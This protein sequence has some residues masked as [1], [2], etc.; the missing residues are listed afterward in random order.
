[1]TP[2]D[3]VH[4]MMQAGLGAPEKALT[5]NGK[6][7]RF[8]PKKANWYSLRETRTDS[9]QYIVL[10]SFGSWKTG[11]KYKVEVD[12]Q[13]INEAER[14]ELQ[15]KR[16]A[17]AD[18]DARARAAA[19]ARAAMTAGEL[20]AAASRTGA[21]DY[22]RRKGVD[23]E[24][25]RF[26][27]DG[28]IVIP[29]LRYDLPREDALRALQQI[30]TDGS[31]RFTKGLQKPGVCLRLGLVQVGEPMLVCEGYAT[32][33]TL[34]MA[35]GKRL[36]VFVAL[37]AGNLLPVCELLRTLYPRSKLLICAD[38]DYRTPGNP[39]REKAHKASRAVDRCAYTYPVF[40]PQMRGA[41]DTDFNDLHVRFGLNVVQR[42]LRHVLPALGSEILHAA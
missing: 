6:A 3:I 28:S 30:F 1:M 36:P 2:Q 37:D 9:G 40:L 14:A 22:L 21:S 38:D 26:L 18:A 31:K 4:Q 20:W 16:Q 25:C 13:G 12:W 39:V 7:Q 27:P 24:A 33:L 19:A 35:V 29:L 5:L 11:E 8:G 10:G 32:G 17:Q 23:A 34:R 41:K 42:Q 15:A